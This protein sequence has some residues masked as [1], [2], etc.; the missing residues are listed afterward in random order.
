[1]ETQPIN[2]IAIVGPTASGKTRLAARLARDTGSEVIS[3]DSRQVYRGLDI[4]SGKDLGDYVVN[5]VPVPYHLIDIADPREEFSVF[6]YQRAFRGC[7][8]ELSR[9]GIVPILAGGT[10]LYI[11]AVLRDF[12]MEEVPENR[13]LRHELRD[14]SE[15][16]LVD[17]LR[18]AN[19]RLHNTSDLGDRDRLL[20]AI[21]IARYRAEVPAASGPALRPLVTGV[22]WDRAVLRRRISD[23]LEAR[24]SGGLLEE[25]RRL[26]E[27]GVSW[28]RL[29]DLGLEYRYIGLHLKGDLAYDEMVRTLAIRIGQ[30]A[31]RQETWFRGMERR[32]VPIRWIEG[33]DYETLRSLVMAAVS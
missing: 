16:E 30:F 22:R 12:R 15:E 28:E 21:E 25:V 4:G 14:R 31:K 32:G 29:H 6:S 8:A 1:M 7:F 5:G 20:R 10:G 26:R 9:Q 17:L 3:A 2:L 24:L 23:R 18:S 11:E 27:S 19:P 13:E 33:D